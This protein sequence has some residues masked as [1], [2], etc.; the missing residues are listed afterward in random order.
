MNLSLKVK[1]LEKIE[2]WVEENCEGPRWPDCYMGSQTTLE[3]LNAATSVFDAVVEVQEYLK[4]E[5]ND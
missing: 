1:L 3:M 4:A 2:E 5:V